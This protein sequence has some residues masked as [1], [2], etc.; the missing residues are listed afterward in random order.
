VENV[1]TKKLSL[2]N[3]NSEDE[4]TSILYRQRVVDETKEGLLIVENNSIL[5][6][7]EAFYSMHGLDSDSV[8]RTKFLDLVAPQFHNEFREKLQD[9]IDRN[10]SQIRMEYSRLHK[11]GR[12]IPTELRGNPVPSDNGRAFVGICLDIKDRKQSEEELKQLKEL[13]ENILSSSYDS[14]T[15]ID[16]KGSIIY[17]S[18]ASERITHYKKEEV[19]GKSLSMFYRDRELFK[20]NIELIEKTKGPISYEAIILDREGGEHIMFISRS[21]LKDRKGNFIGSVGVC[22]DI[23]ERRLMEERIRERERLAYIGQLTTL[24]AHEIR[25]PLSSV[26]MNVQILAKKLDLSG[27]DRRRIEIVDSEIKKLEII[28]EEVLNFAKPMK[29]SLEMEDVNEI[30]EEVLDTL[31]EKINEKYIM[32]EKN[33]SGNLPKILLDRGKIE[34]AVLNIV[35]NSIDALR[36]NGHIKVITEVGEVLEEQIIKVTISDN[37]IG[38]ADVDLRSIFEQFYT[39]KL[40][41]T[42]LG[43]TNV[44]KVIEAHGGFIR[45]DSELGRGTSVYMFLRGR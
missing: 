28:L 2:Y 38:I 34:Q 45:V 29:L 25:N 39:T 12:K 22:K 5:F 4:L 32:I 1:K 33:L 17:F 16:Q 10:S 23:T 27:N 26:K 9:M 42:G 30:V 41:G 19:I 20:K 24:L 21:P 36:P 40:Q 13:S 14:I 43:L 6:A 3:S 18:P 44:K 11:D 31:G 37:G 8:P 7:N 35:L 15:V